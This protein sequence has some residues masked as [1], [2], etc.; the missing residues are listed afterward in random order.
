MKAITVIF[1]VVCGAFVGFALGVAGPLGLGLLLN[2]FGV[3]AVLVTAP[4]GAILGAALGVLTIATRPRLF[5]AT[6]L[7]LAIL[8][9]GFYYTYS[10]LRE[11]DR[12]RNF[13]LEVSGAPGAEYTGVLLVDGNMQKLKGNIPAKFEF[14]AFRIELAVAL[15]DPNGEN[16]IAIK[17]SA[18]GWDLHT[19]NESPIGIY[20]Q[21]KSVG[22]SQVFGDTSWS[23]S[24][25]SG[26]EVDRLI[27]D[28]MI[29]QGM[30]CHLE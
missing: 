25:M 5:L 27:K 24:Q 4:A 16:N 29:P 8:F 23:W 13:V 18:D 17:V 2:G 14:E 28:Q 1:G 10:T 7:P 3:I 30:C 9:I 15:V 21:L 12:P 19:G 11:M 6:F 26:E 22:Y 20:L